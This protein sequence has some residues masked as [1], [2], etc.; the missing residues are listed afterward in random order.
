[1]LCHEFTPSAQYPKTPPMRILSLIYEYPP[2]GGGGGVVAAALNEAL[3]V[4]GDEVTVITSAMPDL[5]ASEVVRNVRISRTVCRRRHRHYTTTLELL[6]GLWPA[7]RQA[8][9]LVESWNPS[10]IHTHF[11]VPSGIVAWALSIRYGIPY[12]LTAHGSDV[13]HYNPDRFGAPHWLMGPLW[14]AIVQRAASLTTASR[15]LAT[16]IRQRTDAPLRIIPNGLSADRSAHP[17]A[18]RQ[19]VLVVARL[20]PRKGVQYFVDAVG[21]LPAATQWEFVV[22]GD[23]PYL[24]ALQQRAHASGARI[25]FVGFKD[26]MEID[27]LYDAAAIFVFPSIQENFPMV[28]LEA[29][30]AGCA[31]I[32]TDADGCADVIGDAGVIVRKADASGLRD[33]LVALLPDSARR[34]EL[35]SRA[36]VRVEQYRWPAIAAQYRAV[37]AEARRP[38]PTEQPAIDSRAEP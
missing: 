4:A 32:T 16:L 8:A 11:I 14:R 27:A 19:L 28:L 38:L 31:I 7:Y 37:F 2:L 35:G 20:F 24:A 12:V 5:P 1:M 34:E 33:A 29:M 25:S 18:K 15:S 23:G 17:G 3:I 30:A 22:A 6:S 10:V 9:R 36:Q 13:P 26:R 21:E